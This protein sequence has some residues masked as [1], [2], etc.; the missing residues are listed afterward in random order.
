MG[1]FGGAEGLVTGSSTTSFF[2]VVSLVLA[3]NTNTEEEYT[4]AT[5]TAEA[6][7]MGSLILRPFV[8]GLGSVTATATATAVANSSSAHLP[9]N[10]TGAD[11]MNGLNYWPLGIGF[12]VT[13]IIRRQAWTF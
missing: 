10:F 9:V 11:V 1:T 12:V 8:A 2:P 5:S 6:V 4:T 7:N 3:G 13:I